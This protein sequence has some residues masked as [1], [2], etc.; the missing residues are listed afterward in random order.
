MK[1]RT[2]QRL[3]W[4]VTVSFLAGLVIAFDRGCL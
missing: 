3:V 1:I 2:L 4:L